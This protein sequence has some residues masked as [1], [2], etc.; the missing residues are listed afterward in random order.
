MKSGTST[1]DVLADLTESDSKLTFHPD[2]YNLG[3][4]EPSKEDTE[5]RKK[6]FLLDTIM[7]G[8][9]IDFDARN[10]SEGR[11]KQSVSTAR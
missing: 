7:S 4:A 10:S 8:S 11:S 2:T 5:G 3:A 1:T 9:N 6:K